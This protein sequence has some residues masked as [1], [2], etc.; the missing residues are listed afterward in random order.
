MDKSN[1]LTVL[2]VSKIAKAS[3]VLFWDSCQMRGEL[4]HYTW[5]RGYLVYPSEAQA[6]HNTLLLDLNA[7]SVDLS[8]QKGIHTHSVTVLVEHPSFAESFRIE[9]SPWQ[10]S[11]PK[12]PAY[13]RISLEAVGDFVTTTYVMR[14]LRIGK[15]VSV[16]LSAP[17]RAQGM[18]DGTLSRFFEDRRLAFQ[19]SNPLWNV[20]DIDM[21]ANATLQV[22][23]RPVVL[24]P[25]RQSRAGAMVPR[26]AVCATAQMFPVLAAVRWRKLCSRMTKKTTQLGRASSRRIRCRKFTF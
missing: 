8:L 14:V 5:S 16:S 18:D 6:V 20:P 24:A 7:D 12:G 15:S 19:L 3:L 23:F 13:S 1:F 22:T 2:A 21:A 11:L 4:V 26:S 25:V 9:E 10:I 17:M